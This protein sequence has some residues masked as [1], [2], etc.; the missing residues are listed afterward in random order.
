MLEQGLE[1]A[2]EVAPSTNDVRLLIKARDEYNAKLVPIEVQYRENA[3]SMLP[4]QHPS[5]TA[6][7]SR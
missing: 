5:S 3:D 2:P 6:V 4:T 7:H 1:I